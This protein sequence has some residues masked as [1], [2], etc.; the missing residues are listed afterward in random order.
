MSWAGMKGS[1]APETVPFLASR[2]GLLGLVRGLAELPQARESG[3]SHFFPKLQLL[4]EE[5]LH[6][7]PAWTK[8]CFVL[9]GS[10]LRRGAPK[11]WLKMAQG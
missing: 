7:E 5:G 9:W 3:G 2:D 8:I 4:K 6:F 1:W 10:I 11:G